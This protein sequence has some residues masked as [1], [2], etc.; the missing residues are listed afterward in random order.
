METW[1]EPKPVAVDE[2]RGLLRPCPRC[3]DERKLPVAA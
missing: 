3:V 2:Q 1:R